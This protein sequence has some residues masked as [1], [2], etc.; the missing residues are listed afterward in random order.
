MTREARRGILYKR[1]AVKVI[2][3]FTC[4][5]GGS[6]ADD[7]SIVVASQ[8]GVSDPAPGFQDATD[9]TK[10]DMPSQGIRLLTIC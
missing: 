2:L 1:L 5:K 6:R 4:S 3:T 8:T 7:G 9:I 10:N